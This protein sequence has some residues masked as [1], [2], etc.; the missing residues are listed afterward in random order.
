[1]SA[2]P[3]PSVFA[4]LPGGYEV[5]IILV[6]ILLLFGSRI[7]K[8][9]RSL[10]QGISQFKKGL[11]EAVEMGSDDEEEDEEKQPPKEEKRLEDGAKSKT[12]NAQTP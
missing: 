2:F 4:G 9:A 5:W 11:N 1:M 12:S 8:V 6:V 10:G 3:L 7:P